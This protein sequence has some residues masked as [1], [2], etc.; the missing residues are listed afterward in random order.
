MKS[1]AGPLKEH[2]FRSNFEMNALQEMVSSRPLAGC[3]IDVV[4][5]RARHQ[6]GRDAPGQQEH[7]FGVNLASIWQQ[8]QLLFIHS[9]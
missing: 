2:D 8:E 6:A 3:D 7:Q 9:E 4:H 1:E 5:A